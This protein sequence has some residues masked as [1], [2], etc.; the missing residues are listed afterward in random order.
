MWVRVSRLVWINMRG[1]PQQPT[2]RQPIFCT[3]LC[4]RFWVVMF[5]RKD[6]WLSRNVYD[7]IFRITTRSPKTSLNTSRCWSIRRFEPMMRSLLKSC[8][9]MMRVNRVRPRSLV[10]NTMTMYVSSTWADSRLS[11][12][13]AHTLPAQAISACFGLCP[14]QELPL[15]SGV[16]RHWLVMLL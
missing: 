3:P 2:T 4:S 10:K 7:S 12:A 1:Q 8:R 13:V 11:F 14:N 5:S 16:L 9:W 15:V 6:L